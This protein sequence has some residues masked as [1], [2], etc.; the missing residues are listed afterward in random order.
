[1][2]VLGGKPDVEVGAQRPGYLLGEEG[3]QAVAGD[4]ADDLAD[5]ESPGERVVASQGPRLPDGGLR[6]QPRRGGRP[7][8]EVVGCH[9]IVPGR[10]ARGV[11]EQVPHLHVLLARGGELG[12]VPGHRRGQV[13]VA[14]G[15]ID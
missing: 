15:S 2:V 11:G 5:Q 4:P 12:P 10:R 7:V 3:A 1:V 6:G 14:P 13:E 9:R 8:V